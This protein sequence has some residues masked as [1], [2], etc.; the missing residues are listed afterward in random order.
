MRVHFVVVSGT[1][2]GAEHFVLRLAAALAT[3]TPVT[4]AGSPRTPILAAANALGLATEEVELGR[5]LGRRTAAANLLVAPSARRRLHALI[6]RCTRDGWCVLQFKWEE[7]LWGAEVVPRRVCLIEHGAI[8]G[9]VLRVPSARRRLRRAFRDAA[10]VLAVSEPAQQGIRALCGRNAPLLLAGVDPER[11]AAAIARRRVVRRQLG[12]GDGEILLTYA[13]RV[14]RD[15]GV[16]DLVRLTAAASDRRALILGDGPA[17]T[18]VRQLVE[19][20]GIGH[21][22]SIAGHVRDPLPYLAASDAAVLLSRERGEG[23]P[24]LAIESL[25]VGTPVI[26][27]VSPAVEALAAEFGPRAIHVIPASHPDALSD[28]LSELRIAVRPEPVS[29]S[30]DA[31]AES[32]LS[33]LASA[34]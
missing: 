14:A 3:H 31:S 18:Q 32:F 12:V 27:L 7:L 26:G 22:V 33:S 10:V 23:R 21:R 15:K 34:A 29:T 24:L 6:E 20:S 5:K 11:A 2:G 25:A 4:I 17:L 13:G 28:V 19:R 30:W 8:P 1:L 9:S 16:L